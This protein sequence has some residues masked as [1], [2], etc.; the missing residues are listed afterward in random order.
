MKIV[1]YLYVEPLANAS[2]DPTIWGW[3]LAD[4]Y[5]DFE[6]A[7]SQLQ[8]LLQTF[9]THP[10]D[11]LLLRHLAELGDTV[12]VISDRLTQLETL[13]VT[14]IAIEQDY[15][16]GQGG[17]PQQALRLLNQIQAHQRRRRIRQGHARNRLKALPPPGRAPYGYRRGKDR[18]ALD[19]RAAPI[20]KAFFEHFLLYGSLR[21]AVRHLE[22]QHNKKISVSTGRKWLTHPVYRGDLV[23]QDQQVIVDTHVPI[24]SREEAAQV[25]RLLRRNRGLAP[26]AASAPRS[27]AGLVVCGECHSPMSVSRVTTPRQPGEYL[28]LR[29]K[30][31]PRRPKCS[32]IAYQQV[33]EQTIAR[34]CQ[35]LP[36]AVA[37]MRMAGTGGPKDT[38]AAAIANKQKLLQQL[39]AFVTAEVLDPQTADLRAYRL[40]TEI[41]EIATQL[42]QLPPENLQKIAQTISI[43]QFWLDLSET[44]RRFYFRE[45][46]RQIVLLRQDQ[47]WSLQLVF[48]F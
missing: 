11:Y 34:I 25:D 17:T 46:I 9:Q 27:L 30:T 47:A 48:V 29:P 45:F 35:D 4:I 10:I 24:V 18:Y 40:R 36:Q 41:A 42:S 20:V 33:L 26:R 19:R 8:Q 21:G 13:G 1:A 2:L 7:R 39:P 12:E 38:L 22:K 43:S 5:Q 15:A 37:G 23:Y 31:C 6:P 28:Y 3:E 14:I 32:A 44:E 16:S